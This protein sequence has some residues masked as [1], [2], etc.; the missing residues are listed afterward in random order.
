MKKYH[1]GILLALLSIFNLCSCKQVDN[2]KIVI[3][4]VLTVNESNFQDD[5]GI[6]SAWLEVF[7]K[8][9]RS[10]NIAGYILRVS[11]APG[12]TVTYKIPKGDVLTLIPPRQHALFWADGAPNRGTFHASFK[13]NTD[14]TN[15]IGLYDSG[16]AL[17][18]AIT[19]PVLKTNTSFARV[20]DGFVI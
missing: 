10:V 15:W 13:L 5:Y 18:D 11:N 19:I 9:Y 17:I 4:E 8:S 20:S 1:L 16:N 6:H 2:S 7:N 12:D 14:K 3:N